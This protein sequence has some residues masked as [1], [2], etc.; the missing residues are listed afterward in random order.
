MTNRDIFK[1]L[2]VLDIANNHFG[3]VTHAKKIIERFSKIIKKYKMSA[4]LNFNL[5]I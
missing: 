1:D 5:E 2:Y 4:A 3:S